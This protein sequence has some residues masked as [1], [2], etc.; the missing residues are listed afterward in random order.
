[1]PPEVTAAPAKPP[2][3]APARRHWGIHLGIHIGGAVHAFCRVAMALIVI[4]A[5]CLA[6][7][8][9]RL[10]EGP[11]EVPFIAHRIE[12]AVNADADAEAAAHPGVPPAASRMHIGHAAIA[13]EG[14]RFGF[15]RPL[16]LRLEDI[17]ATDA[18]G[19]TIMSVPRAEVSLSVAE[20]ALGRIRPR[21]ISVDG[22]RLRVVRAADGGL[23][24]D[25]GSLADAP[26]NAAEAVGDHATAAAPA[27]DNPANSL[28]AELSRPAQSDRSSP[29]ASRL[30]QLRR[31]RIKDAQVTVIDR[32]LGATWQ[33]PEAQ[34]DI[35]RLPAGGVEGS[36]DIMLAL[37][38]QRARFTLTASLGADARQTRLHA[39]LAEVAPAALARSA[40]RLA[41]LSALDAPV[42]L[43]A[44]AVLGPSLALRSAHGEVT[45]GRGQAVVADQAIP[46][47]G[48]TA[49]VSQS[50]G[51]TTLDQLRLTLIGHP[52]ATPTVI[53]AEGDLQADSGQP[54]NG[55]PGSGKMRGNLA[56][57]LDQVAFADL[58]TLWPPGT[59][60]P[61]TRPWLTQNVTAGTIRNGQFKVGLTLPA[62]FSD[63]DLSA[64][65]GTMD[66]D[67]VTI[68]WLRP[69]PPVEN[70]KAQLRILDPDSLEIVVAGGHQH[71][72]AGSHGDGLAVR[73]GR[74]RIVG[75][76]HPH[77]V[78]YIDTDIAGPLAEAVALLREK[79]LHL[80]DRHPLDLR[81]PSGQATAK[82]SVTLP[83]EAEVTAEQV[84]IHADAHIE[85]A[86]L[87]AIA[88]GRNLDQGV[89]DLSADTEGLKATG[90]AV[91]AG[92]AAQL[93]VN[94]DFR[95]GPP[96]QIL[97]QVTVTGRAD[98]RQLAAAG[99]DTRTVLAGTMAVAGT[100]AERRDGRA[101]VGLK[102]NLMDAELNATP[103]GWRKAAGQPAAGEL[104][105]RLD[106]G[107]L[108][109]I[110]LVTL[111]AP[112]LS[113]LGTATYSDGRW[114]EMRLA[115]LT[116]G[117]TQAQGTVRIPPPGNGAIQATVSG[118]QIDLS[119]RLARSQ[120]P[121]AAAATPPARPAAREERG[122]PWIVDAR[123]DRAIMARGQV[124]TGLVLHVEN[125]GLLFRTVRLDG[126]TAPAAPFH[127][128]IT[129]EPGGRRLDVTAAD[130]GQLLSGLDALGDMVGGKLT[131]TGRF[132]DNLPDRP[133]SGTANIEDFRI[134]NA[135][136]VGKLLQAMTLY[137]LVEALQ[138]PGL[139]FTRL[140]APF[141]YTDRT[142]DLGDSRAFSASLGL[143]AKGHI[144]LDAK[145]AEL[146]GTIVPAYFFNSLLGDVPLVGRL[147]S[148]EKGSGLFAATYA[149][150]GPLAD[151]SVSVNPL[152][153]LTPG[154]LRGV[155]RLF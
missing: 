151:P 63:A 109:A 110:D 155:F 50:A 13:W 47:E 20:L 108:A 75:I 60:G 121:P 134:R 132:A 105:L 34:I 78:A 96:S 122:T 11:L 118:T 45:V 67:G 147:F 148:P 8:A 37:G 103:F 123:F 26:E 107:K 124:A 104:K 40:P 22:A 117:R 127:L 31:V 102:V 29:R 116:I 33:A 14:W 111:D 62:D 71:P 7:L 114:S 92:F 55:H 27:S 59:G 125:D 131:L 79:R 51:R 145:T 43:T 91:I 76:V 77:Q 139:G 4:V 136:W 19:H 48:L 42:S 126:R 30:S 144:D 137:G 3:A 87:T 94:M 24:L 143:T 90:H 130:A 101:D 39:S 154:F 89:I 36:A 46:I 18:A 12:A 135:P 28:F 138:G 86:H 150:H 10:S 98:A 113:V 142:L 80:F 146:T 35:R 95:A 56:L 74:M 58:H 93:A 15:D 84:G 153:A 16:D 2:R 120:H 70:V 57:T 68:H 82:L 64:A 140:E 119:G 97:Q 106:H 85:G 32:Q 112:E 149:V 38:D 41:A 52:G 6:G 88:A 5:A 9:W 65:T 128:A 61:G 17:T 83:L 44:D 53:V 133:L 115:R 152:A 100:M 25:L 21:A 49:K 72:S 54:N 141:R 23:S 73:G 66:A 99:L 1:M 81:D 69:I 129:P